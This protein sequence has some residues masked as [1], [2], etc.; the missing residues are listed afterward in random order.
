MRHLSTSATSPSRTKKATSSTRLRQLVEAVIEVLVL[1]PCSSRSWSCEP[2]RRGLA[3]RGRRHGEAREQQR[4]RPAVS[5]SATISWNVLHRRVPPRDPSRV[6]SWSLVRGAQRSRGPPCAHVTI[7]PTRGKVMAR[8][9][10]PRARCFGECVRPSD[11]GHGGARAARRSAGCRIAT[12]RPTVAGLH[13]PRAE[14][15]PS[16]IPCGFPCDG[17]RARRTIVVSSPRGTK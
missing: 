3:P 12:S 17:A 14:C 7:A 11:T 6:P 2:V 16:L 10:A 5:S 8:G 15:N 4:A 9:R 13:T 1:P